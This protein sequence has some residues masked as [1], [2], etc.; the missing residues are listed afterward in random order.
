MLTI[1]QLEEDQVLSL[2]DLYLYQGHGS[3]DLLTLSLTQSVGKKLSLVLELPLS[4]T[5]S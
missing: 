5:K 2:S 1:S 4:L 3:C